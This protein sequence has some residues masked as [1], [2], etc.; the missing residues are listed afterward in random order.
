MQVLFL[1][2]WS[3]ASSCSFGC[4]SLANIVVWE[5]LSTFQLHSFEKQSWWWQG[6]DSVKCPREDAAGMFSFLVVGSEPGTLLLN[7]LAVSTYSLCFPILEE[8]PLQQVTSLLS[9]FLRF[10]QKVCRQQLF[11]CFRYLSS[12]KH[13]WWFSRLQG[14]Y[15]TTILSLKIILIIN[16]I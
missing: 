8:Y 6:Q 16:K 4:T 3:G 14:D 10:F 9:I 1:Q 2:S 12:K 13:L 15:F 5:Q 7:L 11:L